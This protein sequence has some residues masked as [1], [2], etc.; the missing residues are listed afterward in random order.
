ML[1]MNS[2]G[3]KMTL[4]PS[5]LKYHYDVNNSFATGYDGDAWLY[6][7][8]RF[9]TSPP[10]MDVVSGTFRRGDLPGAKAFK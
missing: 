5:R 1:L 8:K 10:C 9:A 7:K 4:F 2:I 6:P 3:K